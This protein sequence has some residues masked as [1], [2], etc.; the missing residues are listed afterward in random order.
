MFDEY[1][2]PPRVERLVPPASAA[3]VPVNSTGVLAEYPLMEDNPFAP[4]DNDH[5]IN[6]FVPEPR[7]EASSSE[8]LSST[9]YPYVSQT[10]H[11]LEK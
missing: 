3:Q 1:L 5:F 7:S 4:I 9:E 10:L 8:D 11:H 6:M 2:E